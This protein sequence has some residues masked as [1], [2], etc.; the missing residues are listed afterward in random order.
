MTFIIKKIVSCTLLFYL[1]SSASCYHRETGK[2]ANEQIPGFKEG[3][4]GFDL[5]FLQKKDAGLVVLKSGV[6]QLIVSPRYQAKVFTS[7]AG[8]ESGLSF[9]WINYKAFEK[10][11][12]HMNAY[13]GENRLWLGPEGGKYSLFFKPGSKMIFDNWK[14]PAAIDTENWNV[15]SKDSNT[16]SL[17][18]EMNLVNYA[19][20]QLKLK[21][22]RRIKILERGEI[23]WRTG[24]S[25]N[26]SVS[27]IGYETENVLIN[28]G[29]RKWT[30]ET[31]MPCVWMLDMFKPSPATIIVVPFQYSAVDHFSKFA[32]TRYFGEIPADRIKHNDSLLVFRADGKSRGKL[33]ILANKAKHLAGSYDADNKVLTIIL[34][35]LDGR[36]PYLNQ[37]WNITKPAFSGDAVNAYNDG[38]LAD[39]TRMGPFYEIESSSPAALLNP[40]ESLV[41]KHAVFHFTGDVKA[42]DEIS[43]MLLGISLENMHKMLF[44][45]AD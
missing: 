26:D 15:M 32:S 37:E 7:T 18:K 28:K 1:L 29:E 12:A 10:T 45:T 20:T 43:K 17:F 19:G 42:L 40:E 33:G 22:N 27:M 31:G 9:G 14:T 35:D 30:A 39:G 8:G 4:F 5:Q 16:V 36:A 2:Q 6:S 44:P 41:H 3:E 11:D 24:I 34:F 25:A 23:I 21:V 13:G 38:P